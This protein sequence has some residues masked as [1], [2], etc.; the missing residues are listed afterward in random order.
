MPWERLPAGVA[1]RLSSVLVLYPPVNTINGP[2]S[3]MV[4]TSSIVTAP[5]LSF[6]GVITKS[7]GGTPL[8]A[9]IPF[10][11]ALPTPRVRY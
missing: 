3:L 9:P 10:D 4:D 7:D 1:P 6:M 11:P 2:M 5:S 8:A